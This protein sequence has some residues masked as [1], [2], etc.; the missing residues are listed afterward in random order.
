[1]ADAEAR[2]FLGDLW[3]RDGDRNTPEDFSIERDLGWPPR[4]EQPGSGF[5]P[6]RELFNQLLFEL[7]EAFSEKLTRGLHLWDE[8]VDYPG[9]D[10]E[11]Y[12]FVLGSDNVIYVSLQPSGPTT[13]NIVDPVSTNNLFWREY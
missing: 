10:D 12:A 6:E 13:G 7:Q 5:E 8:R 2:K 3:A 11:G 1:M 4:Y 9:S